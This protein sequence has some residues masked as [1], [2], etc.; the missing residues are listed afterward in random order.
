MS[1]RLEGWIVL[2]RAEAV[3]A[4]VAEHE[5]A[6]WV[7]QV[8]ILQG[9]A[10]AEQGHATEGVAQMRQGLAAWQ[11][12]GAELDR[13]FFLALPATGIAPDGAMDQAF[14]P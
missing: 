1:Y 7:A 14:A 4:L 5:F 3:L 11:E 13:P 12:T 2:E 6:Q 8:M 9:W 10:L